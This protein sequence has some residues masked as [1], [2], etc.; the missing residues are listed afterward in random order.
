MEQIQFDSLKNTIPSGR[1]ITY[2]NLVCNLWLLRTAKHIV[3]MTIG[4]GGQARM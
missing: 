2:S 3:Y 4:G 1:N